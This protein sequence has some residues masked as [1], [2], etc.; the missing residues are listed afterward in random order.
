MIEFVIL[1]VYYN[2]PFVFSLFWHF[3]TFETTLFGEG[4]VMRICVH[5]DL[6]LGDMTL[7][8]GHDAP[9]S[10]GQQLCEILSRSNLGVSSYGPDK[11]FWSVWTV[12]LTLEVWP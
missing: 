7:G 11:D 2:I 10:H 4:S 12:T 8:Q 9:L 1:W 6:E 3:S 5:Y